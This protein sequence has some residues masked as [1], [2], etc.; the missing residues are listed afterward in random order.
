MVSLVNALP[1]LR[2]G[3][4]VYICNM[5]IDE[6]YKIVTYLVDKYQGTYISPEDFNNVINM[7][8]YQ[9]AESIVD[10]TGNIT[11]NNPKSPSGLIVNSTI[12]DKLSK[13]YTEITLNVSTTAGATLGT[14][15]KPSGMWT[16]TS[17]R[18]SANRPIKKVFDDNLATHLTNPIDSPSVDN[19][20][21]MEIGGGTNGR[22]KF[23]P[24]SSTVP[25]NNVISP[26]L[27]YIRTPNKM[28]W[29]YTGNLEYSQSGGVNVIPTSGSVQPEWGDADMI[30]IIY[31][32]IGIIG[33]P[34]K[35]GELIRASQIVK[36]Q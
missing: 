36:A 35:D 24:N 9:Y 16:A 3:F 11:S 21:Y 7:A 33:I 20:I 23:Y 10:G 26:I 31:I 25:A 19:P 6:V 29:A 18:T 13:F 14:A 34:L 17:L 4:F 15:E 8:Q 32:A 2:W 5:T 30:E 28:V 12:S 27:G 22:F 1:F